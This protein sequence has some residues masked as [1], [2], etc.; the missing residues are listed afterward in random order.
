MTSFDFEERRNAI[1]AALLEAYAITHSYEEAG[2]RTAHK[3][4]V[5]LG[6]DPESMLR[7]V[8]SRDKGCVF[9]NAADES[10][11]DICIGVIRWCIDQ[12]IPKGV[13]LQ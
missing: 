11:T 2:Y 1:A 3:L 7:A 12:R 10:F 13:T 8:V 6:H 4:I 9:G 5:W